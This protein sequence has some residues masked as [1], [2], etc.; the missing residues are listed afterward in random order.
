MLRVE[1]LDDKG[2]PVK[3]KATRVVIYDVATGNPLSLVVE[4]HEGAYYTSHVDDEDF[5]SLLES[6]G[7]NKTVLVDEITLSPRIE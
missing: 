1:L 2:R 7:V 4:F 5:N 6:L 3:M